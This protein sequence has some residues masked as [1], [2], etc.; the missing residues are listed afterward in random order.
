M[1]WPALT[2]VLS[3]MMWLAL[4]SM[5]FVPQAAH[6]LFEADDIF[7][8]KAGVLSHLGESHLILLSMVS[9]RTKSLVDSAPPELSL[10]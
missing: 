1:M 9:K 6:C 4:A 3:F 7:H 8:Q 10:W 5:L 2:P